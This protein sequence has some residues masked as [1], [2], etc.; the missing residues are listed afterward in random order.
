MD[1]EEITEADWPKKLD[2]LQEIYTAYDLPSDQRPS[3]MQLE[4]DMEAIEHAANLWSSCAI[5]EALQLREYRWAADELNHA[6]GIGVENFDPPLARMGRAFTE[7]V[8]RGDAKAARR[9]R[10]EIRER[11]KLKGGPLTVRARLY[12]AMTDDPIDNS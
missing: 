1:E 4:K 12:K 9:Y 8:E 5:G 3:L 2:M 11:I 6:L 10:T 7:A